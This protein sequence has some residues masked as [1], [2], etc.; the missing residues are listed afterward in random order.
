MRRT[1][2][3]AFFI[4]PL[5]ATASCLAARFADGAEIF[6]TNYVAAQGVVSAYTTTGSLIS[7]SLVS[8]PSEGQPN[9]L[10]ASA[11]NLYV[12]SGNLNNI[13]EYTLSGATVSQSFITHGI[14]F[15]SGMTVA[16]NNLYVANFANFEVSEFNATT[17]AVENASLVNLRSLDSYSSAPTDVAVSGNDLYVASAVSGTGSFV[18]GEY[19][20]T[21]GAAINASLV[22]GAPYSGED[23]F[24]AVSGNDLFI[25]NS[26]LGTVGEYDATT[27]AAINSALIPD[28][29]EP[30]EIKAYNGDLFIAIYAQAN[31][32]KGGIAEYTTSGA[33]VNASLVS[34]LTGAGAIVVTPEPSTFALLTIAA[35]AVIARA[36]ASRLRRHPG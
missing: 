7:Q 21:T 27:G 8:V 32:G 34:G 3:V 35:A 1:S 28:L 20:A 2:S 25:S 19:N 5:L 17:G 11:T 10:A 13:S 18:V 22:T 26:G 12:A 24:L 29:N 33:L 6:V 15:P 23:A 16:G 4:V 9:G 36:G 14:Q 30:S 31:T